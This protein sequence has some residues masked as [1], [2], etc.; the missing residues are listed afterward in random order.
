M[1]RKQKLFTGRDALLWVILFFGV[2]VMANGIMIWIALSSEPRLS[3]GEPTRRMTFIDTP[4]AVT[5]ARDEK[6]LWPS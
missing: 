6:I 3:T 4:P 1:K 5:S 2:I